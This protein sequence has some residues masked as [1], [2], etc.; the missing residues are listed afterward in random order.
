MTTGS[1]VLAVGRFVF[2]G[3]SGSV[4]IC[5]GYRARISVRDG[6]KLG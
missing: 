1:V 5:G 3:P 2:E 4:E 6:R